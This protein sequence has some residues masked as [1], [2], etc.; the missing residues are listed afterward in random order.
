M[1]KGATVIAVLN[2]VL[3]YIEEHLAEEIDVAGL[4]SA[5]GTTEYHVRR[6]F[7]SLAGMPLAAKPVLIQCCVKDEM[8]SLGPCASWTDCPQPG[9]AVLSRKSLTF[10]KRSPHWMVFQPI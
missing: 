9:S 10:N 1:R 2:Q 8:K 5:L 7:S 4:T 3:G 6:M